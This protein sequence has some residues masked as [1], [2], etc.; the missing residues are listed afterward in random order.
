VLAFAATIGR[1]PEQDIMATG[2]GGKQFAAALPKN[3]RPER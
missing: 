2:R 1:E 3:E